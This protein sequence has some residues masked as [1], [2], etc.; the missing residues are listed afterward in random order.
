M[1]RPPE[2]RYFARRLLRANFDSDGDVG[3]VLLLD[4]W[5][6]WDNEFV[7]PGACEAYAADGDDDGDV[8]MYDEDIW[9]HNL[10]HTL[11]LFNVAT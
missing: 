11:Q 2:C 5:T 9:A 1:N 10:G 7:S 8:D 4:D 6:V 3:P